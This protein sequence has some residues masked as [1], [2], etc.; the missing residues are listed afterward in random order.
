MSKG[1]AITAWFIIAIVVVCIVYDVWVCANYG[2]ES[3][4]SWVTWTT[5]Q[6]YP[7]IPFA[8]GILCGHLFWVQQTGRPFPSQAITRTK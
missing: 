3:T 1:R 7:V 4:I 5:C 8:A 2:S 6:H